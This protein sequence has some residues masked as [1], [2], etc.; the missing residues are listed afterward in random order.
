MAINPLSTDVYTDFSGLAKLK[1]QA[2]DKSPE[3][4]QKVAKQFESLFLQMTLKSMR[5]ASFGNDLFD[6]DKSLFYRDMYDKQL[7]LHLAQKSGVGL[8][9]LIVKQLGGKDS[10]ATSKLA[11]RD[12]QDY[13]NH[14]NYPSHQRFVDSDK[15][16]SKLDSA[17][18]YKIHGSGKITSKDIGS[19]QEFLQALVP[20]AIKAGNELGVHPGIL[21]AQAA[22]ESGWGQR[23]I[24]HSDG[25][26]SHNLFGIKA[27][28]S[29]RGAGVNA[30]TV[31]FSGG[32]AEKRLEKFRSYQNYSDSFK[33]YVDFIKSNPRYGEALKNARNPHRYMNSLH[34]AGYATDPKYA[35]K[36]LRIFEQHGLKNLSLSPEQPVATLQ[37]SGQKS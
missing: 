17:P 36:V 15:I 18:E 4:L 25:S 7:A 19:P 30:S 22:L 32:S 12:L 16:Q 23:V 10:E 1:N 5:E 11:G 20:D 13:Q 24:R 21:L 34:R 31:E 3:S 37:V 35:S 27:D 2:K 26:S 29:W 6:N 14:P 8:A 9:D 33:D 28:P